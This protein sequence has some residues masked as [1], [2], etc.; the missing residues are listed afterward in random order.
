VAA[1][2]SECVCCGA[3][4]WSAYARAGG[5]E[6]VRCDACGFVRV[7]L[8]PDVDVTTLYDEDYFWG[9]AC[10]SGPLIP[11]ARSPNPA[12]V[13]RRRYWLGLLARQTGGAGRLLDVGCGAG[14]LLD[15]AR[16]EG[17]DA[18]GQDIAAPGVAEARARGH[19]VC[20]GPL[21]EC[22]LEAESFDA[23]TMIE[24]IEHLV[25]PR[26]TLAE[27]RRLLRP[28]GALLVATGDVGSLRARLR[29]GRWSYVR[30]PRHVSYFTGDALERALRSSGFVS[31]TLVPTYNLAHP[32]FP[33]LG[34]PRARPL[35][36]VARLV[37]RATRME[38]NVI[39]LA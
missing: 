33:V 7:V 20:L 1:S 34:A 37:R 13:A 14:A 22:G 38:Q 18:H 25:D 17:W 19:R 27:V 29:K 6:L 12:Y 5:Y 9:R 39:A 32:S 16:D 36:R 23:A 26:E 31:A 35:V 15:V 3:R 8:P 30:P 2:P 4:R 24:V 11:E 28:G 21:R 10:D